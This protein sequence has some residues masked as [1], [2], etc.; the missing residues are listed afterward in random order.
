VD[1]FR[2]RVRFPPPPPD[3]KSSALVGWA[4]S[5]FK[6]R[7]N[8]YLYRFSRSFWFVKVHQSCL[9]S[10]KKEGNL[11]VDFRE[12]MT[13]FFQ[14][15]NLEAGMNEKLT[16]AQI[17]AAKPK[18]K[19]YKLSD[20]NGL[21]LQV[22]PNGGKWWRWRYRFAGKEKMLSLGVFPE[23]SLREARDDCGRKRR[24]LKAGKDP[25]DLR[26][27]ERLVGQGPDGP[28]CIANSFE[29]VAR[30]WFEQKHSLDVSVGHAET[31]IRRLE[32]YVFP[33][34]GQIDIDEITTTQ[35]RAILDRIK[36]K[37]A[38]ETAHR[39]KSI[40]SQV[41]RYAVILEKTD[42]D[43]TMLLRGYLPAANKKHLPAITDPPEVAKLMKAIDGYSGSLVTR[44]ALQLAPL[45]FVRPGELRHA[46]W[47]EIDL[48]KAEWNIPA[49]KMKMK[50]A[51]LVPLSRQAVAILKDLQPKTGSGRFVFPGARS[52]ARPMSE[53]AILAAL[54][55][56]GYEKD[57]MTGHGFRA[58]ARTILA[59]VLQFPPEYIEH[60]LAH[61]VK[62]PLG[63]AYNRTQYL[64]Q[65]REMMQSWSDYLDGLRNDSTAKVISINAARNN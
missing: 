51:H 7:K 10:T 25:S 64:E 22:N 60:Q 55:S 37:G 15:P 26:K 43:P 56:L 49:E 3:H 2:T 14:L 53:N 28:G 29:S 47:S 41:F 44:C 13:L 9:T 45:V 1:S 27:I 30:I 31:T 12:K 59:E 33:W 19:I 50:H 46:E 38:L 61:T 17:K 36:M 35:I 52:A 62:D 34:L 24:I 40:C 20:G 23:V 5:L 39:V 54:R 65:R 21:F 18:D 6:F 48:D 8:K 11:R 57:Q 58:M 4:F 63:R 32:N 42:R 16:F